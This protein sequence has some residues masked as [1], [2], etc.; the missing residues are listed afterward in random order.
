MTKYFPSTAFLI[1]EDENQT[2]SACLLTFKH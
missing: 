2:F 1:I